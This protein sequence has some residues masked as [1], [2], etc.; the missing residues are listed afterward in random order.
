LA[1]SIKNR[2]LS[3]ID[4]ELFSYFTT[5]KTIHP[6]ISFLCQFISL[7]EKQ[8][9]I[10]ISCL[11]PKTYDKS[12]FITKETEVCNELL[13]ITE[14][15]VRVFVTRD[16][17]EH[18]TNISG[19]NYFVSSLS[20]F[21]SQSKSLENIQTLT[22][23]SGFAINYSKL[24]ELRKLDSVFEVVNR[25]VLEHLY[26]EKSEHLAKLLKYDSKKR[27][28]MFSEEDAEMLQHVP[29]HYIASYLGMKP[30]TLSRIR[31]KK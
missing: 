31:A 28:I 11:E 8:S 18:I 22:K 26:V 17:D 20:S 4:D 5:M 29:L 1:S 16:I 12:H 6:V 23:V 15:Y 25:M 13:F 24:N 2:R 27:Y 19:P 7:N 9:Q 30:E 3:F 14:G 21:I 10:L